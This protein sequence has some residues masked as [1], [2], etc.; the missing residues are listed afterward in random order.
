MQKKTVLFLALS[1]SLAAC[2]SS[3]S[4]N[5]N[6]VVTKPTPS[7][8][9]NP[10]NPTNPAPGAFGPINTPVAVD[11]SKKYNGILLAGDDESDNRF[12]TEVLP[13]SSQDRNEIVVDGKSIALI[14][15]H[16]S[17]GKFLQLNNYDGFNR[18]VS[19]NFLSYSRFGYVEN[20]DEDPRFFSLG[21]ITMNMPTTGTAKYTG[22]IIEIGTHK[23]V[24]GDGWLHNKGTFTADVDF[25]AKTISANL[26]NL[27]KGE[28]ETR[29]FT[30]KINGA[31]F[32]GTSGSG[33]IKGVAGKFYGDNAAEIG[34]VYRG[35]TD[36]HL[37][38]G[39]FGGK[40]QP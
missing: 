36:K 19:G 14:P 4:R 33:G 37:M 2:S 20:K 34:G 27:G 1:L 10:A 28:N 30:A 32:L 38:A 15:A 16:L 29:G 26:I 39:S 25:A 8:P 13:L 6:N 17:A 40:K 7:N 22:K 11:A 3:G 35:E 12:K 21:D 18:I 9:A 5:D 24:R 23:T 31:E